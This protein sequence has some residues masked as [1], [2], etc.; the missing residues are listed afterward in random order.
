MNILYMGKYTLIIGASENPT[1]YSNMAI[2]KLVQ[3]GHPVAAIGNKEGKVEGISFSKTKTNFEEIDT[4][5]LYIGQR[6]QPEYYDYVLS[7]N[8]KRIIFN[9]GTENEEFESLANAKGIKTMEACT[10]VLLGTSQY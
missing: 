3:N 1:R 4:V 7:L 9:P 2:K 8:P 5:S 10:L 6:H